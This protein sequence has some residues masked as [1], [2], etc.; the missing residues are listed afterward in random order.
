MMIRGGQMASSQAGLKEKI[1]SVV[2]NLK[3][4]WKEPPKGRFMSFKEIAS[5][6]FGGIG[7][8]LIV[9]MSWICML[10]TTNVFITG[11]IGITPTDMY[12]LYVIAII[13]GIPLTGLRASIV[14]N[15]RGKA[16]KYRPYILLMGIPSALIFIAMVW[17]PYDKLKY[18]VGDG[19]VF[20]EKTADYLA[21]CII[22]LIF[23]IILQF[24]YNFFYD[25][26]ENLI[27]VL[28]PN[29]QERADVASI[30]SIV[31]SLGPSVVNLIMPLVA[32]NVFHTNQTDIRVY[33]L[34]F[35]ILGVLGSAL[36]VIVYANTQEKI[37]QAKTHV[38]QVKFTDAFKA[39]AKNKYFW[40]ISLAG[41]I[42]FLET[43]YTN[44]LAW[45]YNYGGACSGNMYSLIVTLNGNSA[46]W[47]MIMAPFFIR[48]FGKKNVQIVTNLLNI[49]FILAMIIFTGKITPATIWMVLICL[50]CNGIVGAFAH[51]LNPS[52][53]ADIR[54][55]QQYKT[56]ERI[57]G[58][59][60]AVATIGSVI[61]L[62]TSG[63]IPT[64]Q[65]RLGMNVENARRVVN[66]A[67]LMSRILPGA[68]ETI[69]QMLAKQA[70][71]G[72]D[73][74]NAS[75]ALYDVNGVLIPLLRVLILVAAGGAVLNVI[76]F[77]FYDF[78]ERKQ[79]AVIRVLKVRALFE[80]YANKAL[81]DRELVEAID[82]V[83]DAR[84]MAQK[85]P[86]AVSKKDYKSLSGKAKKEAKKAYNEALA[87][88]EEI[89]I[90][91]FVCAELDKFNS[92]NVKRQ[93]ALYQAVYDAGLDGIVNMD[94]N[95]V[96]RELAAAKALPKNTEQEKE[97][98]KIEIE[99][100]KKKLSSH[101]NY[102]KHFGQVKEFAEP[103]MAV[104]DDYFAIEDK[105]DDR[106]TELTK[107]INEAKKA[108]D[109]GEVS[110]LKAELKKVAADRKAARK[111]SKEEMDK[112]AMFNRAADAYITSRKLLVQQENFSHLDE[113][114]AQYEDAKVRAE[115][116][117]RI[118]HEEEEAK[119]KELEAELAAR[120][121]AKKAK[122]NSKK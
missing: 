108:G 58:M 78:T 106:I 59:F 96:K 14:D 55:Y 85:E 33:R 32:E 10:A 17:F 83:N 65:E 39:V 107:E 48:K 28:S 43:A 69:G 81:S 102:V 119:R 3:Y 120:K 82:L 73:I 2:D 77:F 11:T 46:L 94:V 66:D 37:I 20:G 109:A 114:A 71:N 115:E 97:M 68:N 23:N 95:A 8:Y 86:K 117:E 122:K 31:Y 80:D 53:Q 9:S 35:P 101:K 121:A 62:I 93:V 113:I 7:A 103:D 13:A 36:L 110:K 24:V 79:K 52:I 72:Q 42:G 27:H 44:I 51:I 38:I 56:G 118:K 60:A 54:D 34:V 74:F 26:Y 21:K 67:N 50:Y 47:G 91:Q 84:E 76:P 64:L 98:R 57:D 30:K 19:V 6:A 105:C 5:Y 87:Y 92:D 112:H 111:S 4:Y 100:A 61:T 88:N 70:A 29:S 45:L 104:L 90:S 25:A 18:L 116:D 15:T 49:I 63:V 40:I 1:G 41:W 99:L 22:L 75:N 89:E 16:G 12:I